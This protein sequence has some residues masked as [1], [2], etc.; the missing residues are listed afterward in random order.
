MPIRFIE[1]ID[2]DDGIVYLD[3]PGEMTSDQMAA[4]AEAAKEALGA[5]QTTFVAYDG[6]TSVFPPDA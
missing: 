5:V 1:Y 3:D 6:T 2:Q 4:H